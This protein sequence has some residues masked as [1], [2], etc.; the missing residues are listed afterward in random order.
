MQCSSSISRISLSFALLV[1]AGSCG[2]A[3]DAMQV[4][5][6]RA[7]V[8]VTQQ[9]M[10][11]FKPG[12]ACEAAAIARFAA[13][14]QLELEFVRPMSGNAC[15]VLQSGADRAALAR[16]LDRLR[17]DAAIEWAEPDAMLKTQ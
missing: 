12:T 14:V 15:V 7:P 9:L 5:A 10:I 2:A 6:A 11:K 1:M 4:A 13:A 3:P 17:R 16:G 8:T